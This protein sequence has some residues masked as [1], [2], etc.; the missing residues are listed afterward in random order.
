[1]IQFPIPLMGFS[2]F[3]GTGKTTLLTQVLPLLK[4]QGIRVAVVKHAHHNFE[5]DRPGKDSYRLRKAGA[6]QML[7][8]SHNRVALITE[9]PTETE[10]PPLESL[11]NSLDVHH[12]DLVMIEGFKRE[13]F[14]KIELH[15]PSLGHPL[16]CET[17]SDIIALAS[18]AP[19]PGAPPHLPRLDINQ[20]Q[21]IADFILAQCYPQGI[22]SLTLSPEARQ[23]VQ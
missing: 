9:R 5:V 1:M 15:R 13:A 23:R 21:T 12:L 8:A 11:L 2:A 4:A 17:Y 7:V 14:P 16:L 22:G 18:D 20:P 3:S 10:R 6:D 19:V